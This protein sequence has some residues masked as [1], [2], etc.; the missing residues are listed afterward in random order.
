VGRGQGIPEIATA[1]ALTED[2]VRV[3]LKEAGLLELVEAPPEGEPAGL[4][5][6]ADIDAGGLVGGLIATTPAGPVIDQGPKR[7][8]RGPNKPKPEAVGG[9]VPSTTYKPLP[10]PT[11]E[12]YT[13][14]GKLVAK[15]RA[16]NQSIEDMIIDAR[17][18]LKL[19]E[20]FGY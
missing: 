9:A 19:A 8:G 6:A 16:E 2:A 4:P 15:A 5:V 3:K 7:R 13:A 14:L 18:L 11:L 1:L 10:E 20:L 17:R 12:D